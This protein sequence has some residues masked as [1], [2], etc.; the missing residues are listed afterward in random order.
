MVI[1][2]MALGAYSIMAIDN[3]SINGSW[4]LFYQWLLVF[5]LLMALDVYFING[6]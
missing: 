6:Y 1:L 3:Y 5:I 4:C 2:L